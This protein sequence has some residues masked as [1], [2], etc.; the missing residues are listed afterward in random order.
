[1][2][3]LLHD[4]LSSLKLWN[5]MKGSTAVYNVDISS[6]QIQFS[7]KRLRRDFGAPCSFSDRNVAD[8]KDGYIE[9]VPYEDKTFDLTK[10][11]LE[12]GVQVS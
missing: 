4:K 3:Y 12:K 9:C 7:A 11:E 5:G 8:A 1:M 6:F 2:I 10:S